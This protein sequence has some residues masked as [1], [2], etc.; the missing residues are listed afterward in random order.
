[1]L[2][3]VIGIHW[4]LGLSAAMLLVISIGLLLFAGSGKEDRRLDEA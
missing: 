2:G 4:S 1:V 3:S